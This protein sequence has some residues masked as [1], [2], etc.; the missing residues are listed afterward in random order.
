MAHQLRN[1][2]TGAAMAIELHKQDCPS[3]DSEALQVAIRQLRLM[4]S[5]LQRFMGFGRS[6]PVPHESI[7][8]PTIV[9]EVL[10]LVRP[11]ATHAAVELVFAPNAEKL[12]IWGDA[13]S[14]RHMLMN[15]VLNGVEAA[16][17][18]QDGAQVVVELRRQPASRVVLLV[19]DNGPGPSAEVVQRLFEPFVTNKAEGVGLGLSVAR[20]IAEAHGGS[21]SFQRV[22]DWTCFAVELPLEEA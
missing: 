11:A 4:E 14:L 6:Q 12:S 8:L 15:L 19:K 16:K 5:Y 18:A 22:D 10:S 9:E 17:S 1:A 7:A 21:I 13:E 20:H 3:P 2:V